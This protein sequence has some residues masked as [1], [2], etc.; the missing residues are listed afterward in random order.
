MSKNKEEARSTKLSVVTVNDSG[1]MWSTVI[2]ACDKCSITT[3][4]PFFTGNKELKTRINSLNQFEIN[5]HDNTRRL[6][7]P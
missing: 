7:L 1:E 4:S 3:R 2:I 6:Y 5:E